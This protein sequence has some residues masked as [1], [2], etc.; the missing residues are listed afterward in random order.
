MGLRVIQCQAFLISLCKVIRGVYLNYQGTATY[1]ASAA[2][3]EFSLSAR[4]IVSKFGMY[5]THYLNGSMLLRS[6]RVANTTKIDSST[7]VDNI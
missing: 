7:P 3:Y 5:S 6:T 1:L 2:T 4:I